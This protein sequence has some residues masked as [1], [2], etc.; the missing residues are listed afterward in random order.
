MP[1]DR[2]VPSAHRL[3]VLAMALLALAGTACASPRLTPPENARLLQLELVD[4]DS[5]RALPQHRHRGTAWVAGEDSQ[6]YALRLRNLTGGRL[7]VVLSVDGVNVVT[8]ESAAPAQSGYVLEP[9]ASTEIEGWRKSMHE[10]AAFR[11]SGAGESY[12]ARTGRPFDLGVIGAAVFR[13][14]MVQESW[15]LPAPPIARAEGELGKSGAT[16]DAVAEAAAP[17]PLESRGQ[18]ALADASSA[19]GTAHGERRW[20]PTSRTQF[21]RASV[22]PDE[23]VGLRYARWE[24][25]VARGVVRH[26][27]PRWLAREPRAFPGGFVPDP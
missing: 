25:L 11:F 14:A 8:G 9:W 12:A 18:R 4:R 26:P 23:L 15:P 27:E 19:L 21:E 20:S 16:A 7:L 22:R 2:P 13:E 6:P 1:L 17:A 3:P 24:T 10:V 5:G